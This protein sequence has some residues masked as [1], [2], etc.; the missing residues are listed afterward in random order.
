[1]KDKIKNKIKELIN[2]NYQ[3]KYDFTNDM[4]THID[5]RFYCRIDGDC[6]KIY[7]IDNIS[8]MKIYRPEKVDDEY[9]T[10]YSV[11]VNNFQINLTEDE[12]LSLY[13]YIEEAY[14]DSINKYLETNNQ[15][16]NQYNTDDPFP[17]L[18]ADKNPGKQKKGL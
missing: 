16:K 13:Y 6:R 8:I 14:N 9:K 7:K 5:I 18:K 17:G 15:Y 10:K 2:N 3:I 4:E 11:K 1:M 12:E